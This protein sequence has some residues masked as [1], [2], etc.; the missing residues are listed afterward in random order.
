MV[1]KP[2]FYLACTELNSVF[3]VR[4]CYIER[5]LVVI[6]RDD[7]LLISITPPIL[8]NNEVEK[9]NEV[10]LA[11]RFQENTLFPINKWPM[12]VHVCKILNDKISITGRA[13][14]DD[15]KA[16]FWGTIF[17]SYDAAK[18]E[19]DIYAKQIGKDKQDIK[20][21]LAYDIHE[22]TE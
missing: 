2:D 11:V 1:M 10:V 7:Y 6:N 18:R 13:C 8:L 21:Y 9:L 19:T 12:H 14:A 16:L 15:V 20:S 4:T 22:L 3:D 5:Q 17:E